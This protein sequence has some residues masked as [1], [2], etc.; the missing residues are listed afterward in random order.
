MRLL[1][2]GVPEEARRGDLTQPRAERSEALGCVKVGLSGLHFS[3][4]KT[5]FNGGSTMRHPIFSLSVCVALLAFV[6]ASRGDAPQFHDATLKVENKAPIKAYAFDLADVKLLD[7]P[8]RHAQD[9]DL[10]YLLSLDPDRLLYCFRQTAGL[11]VGDAQPFDDK[12]SWER[13]KCELRGHFVGHYLSA[14]ALMVRSTGDKQLLENANKVVAGMAACQA[15]IGSGYLS[16]Y[17]EEEIDRVIA[18]KPVW[19]PW[20]TLHKIFAGL[21]DM[22]VLTGNTQA[23]EVAKKYADWAWSRLGK[24]SDDE[25]QVMLRNEHGGMLDSMAILYS[26]TGEKRYLDLAER[27]FYHKKILDPLSQG[28]D[29]LENIHANT[30]FPKIIGCSRLF[31][32]TGAEKYHTIADTFWNVV[33]RE[34]SYVTGGNSDNEGFSTKAELSKHIGPNST[35]TCNEYNM[36]KLTRHLFCWQPDAQYSDYYERTLYN[37][38]LCSQNP[39]TGM[40]LYYLPLKTGCP[41]EGPGVRGFNTPFSDFWCCT[42]TGVENHAKYGDSIYFNDGGKGLYVNLFI[43]SELNWKAKGVKVRQETKYPET[44]GTKLVFECEKPTELTLS[45]RRPWW[46]GEGFAI[47]VGG[48]WDGPLGKPGSYV[49]FTRTFKSGDVVNVRM[50][51]VLATEGFKDNPDKLA[52]LYGPLVLCGWTEPGNELA[53][54]RAPKDKIVASLKPVAGQPLTFSGPRTVFRTSV[55]DQ[56]G[57]VTF[58]PFYKEFKHAYAIYWDVMDDAG[59]AKLKQA[60]AERVARDKALAA[61]TVDS[62]TLGIGNELYRKLAQKN[63]NT[64]KFNGR[65]WRDAL[66]GGFFAFEMKPLPAGPQELLVTYWGSDAGNREFD[67]LVGGRKLATQ[68]LQNNQ[69]GKFFDVTYPIPEEVTNGKEKVAVKFQALPGKRAGGVFECR[70]LKK[71]K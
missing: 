58:V 44:A 52:L 9:L 32:L 42:G 21:I 33:T 6:A 53:A 48:V 34:R 23:L 39:E 36:L 65:S 8:F 15:K 12:G 57:D 18:G 19:A 50:P 30:Q 26:L 16:A 17:P 24:I 1:F 67:V 70:I 28:A 51:M 7:G 54:I 25:I 4:D 22:Y 2:R 13:P 46:A 55:E 45:I 59:W 63:S 37:Q 40:M 56:P 3:N 35:E 62:L 61:R 66:N 29:P 27:C 68:K 64:G 14:C 49:T 20:Y 31:E 47:D 43:A 11:P 69:P 5:F 10:K 71:E 41:K 38:I 60:M